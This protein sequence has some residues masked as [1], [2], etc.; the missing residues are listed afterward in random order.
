MH[1]SLVL[2][3]S[4]CIK[5]QERIETWGQMSTGPGRFQV[6]RL[7][8]RSHLFAL[9]NPGKTVGNRFHMPNPNDGLFP[10]VCEFGTSYYI[11]TQSQNHE[12]QDAAGRSGDVKYVE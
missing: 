2:F 9:L 11:Q 5:K 4:K 12:I 10:P 6:G 7:A 3:C 1:H 8:A